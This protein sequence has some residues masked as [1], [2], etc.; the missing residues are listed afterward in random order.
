M[1]GSKRR[2]TTIPPTGDPMVCAV[3]VDLEVARES[4]EGLLACARQSDVAIA[5]RGRTR[6]F[7]ISPSRYRL[8]NRFQPTPAYVLQRLERAYKPLCA[9]Q[10]G[11]TVTPALSEGVKKHP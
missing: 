9:A 4:F 2:P 8:L 11:S 6:S 10:R 1:M 7:L 5:H 3:G